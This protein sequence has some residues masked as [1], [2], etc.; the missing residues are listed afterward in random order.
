MIPLRL[1]KTKSLYI[2]IKKE[3][4]PITICQS[5]CLIRYNII[6]GILCSLSGGIV[7]LLFKFKGKVWN[8]NEA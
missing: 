7:N 1:L 4:K 2:V 8:D 5:I 6:S 3:N